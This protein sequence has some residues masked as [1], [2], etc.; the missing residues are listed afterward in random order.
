MILLQRIRA[1]LTS[2]PDSEH[3]M[4]LNR[5][6]FCLVIAAY[7]VAARP[8]GE[9]AGLAV[10]GAESLIGLG[11]FVHILRHPQI[12]WARRAIAMA[13]DIGTIS[14][15][16]YLGGGATSVFFPIYLWVVFGNGF[17]FG[18]PALFTSMGVAVA[19]FIAVVAATPFWRDSMQLS[20]GL[21]L[22]LIILPTY[23]A[24]L[25]RKLSKARL[26][27]EEASQAKSHFLAR[28]SH[29]LRTP[30][31]AIIGMGALL[32]DTDLGD[33]QL[34]MT[35]T[36]RTAAKSLLS[37]IDGLL[38][39]SRIEADLMPI[40]AVDFDL[41]P[42]LAEIRAMVSVQAR[43]K[44]LRLSL[45]VTARTATRLRGDRR[46][47]AEIL[48]NLASNAVKFTDEGSVVI[49]VDAETASGAEMGPA[50]R[51][52]VRF[53]VS[54]T[55]IGIKPEA[56][57]HIFERFTQADETIVNRF[58]GTGLGLAIC[59][60]L[61]ELLGGEIGVE[62]E[63]G[64][65]SIFRVTLDL[66]LQDNARKS[67]EPVP[68][69]AR[70]LLVTLDAA[71][72]RH[73]K[74]HAALWGV[75][76]A[77]FGSAAEAIAF[78][79]DSL[80]APRR[81]I[82][83]LHQA[84]MS[85]D[86]HAVASALHGALHGMPHGLDAE[87]GFPVILIGDAPMAGLPAPHIRS[88][89][90]MVLSPEPS[91]QELLAA[92]A[93]TLPPEGHP[94]PAPIGAKLG[95]A[96]VSR[97]LRILVADDNRINQSVIAKILE[98]AGHQASVVANGEEALDALAD[99]KFDLVLMDVNM[100]V[101]NGIQATKVFRFASLGGPHVPIA[102]LTADIT[103][104]V[105][106]RCREA[107]MDACITKPIEPAR[108]LEIIEQLV[109]GAGAEGLAE[110]RL[111]EIT[112]RPSST[113]IRA[114][115]ID[116]GVLQ[117]L[118]DLG[119]GAFVDDLLQEFLGDADRRLQDFAAAAAAVDLYGFSDLT[120]ALRSGAAN[121]GAKAIFELCMSWRDVNAAELALNGNSFVRQ[122]KVEF[123]R[124]HLAANRCRHRH[125]TLGSS[126][127]AKICAAE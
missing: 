82:L 111:P 69:G 41:L 18:V 30:L 40:H 56:Q 119:G 120:H 106:Q 25:I 37:Q 107:G 89:F 14:L 73:V 8:P 3:E 58:G 67:P 33:E 21:L 52:R 60:K 17:R 20:A 98:R 53:E 49:A 42:L 27:A 103:P 77:S 13:A 61:V 59:K 86:V 125:F 28:V 72:V 46:H 112:A 48:L 39:F 93:L 90:T 19:A 29:E 55:G 57:A 66:D 45:H 65:G 74:G 85:A 96:R 38:D 109:R 12:C 68:A 118:E 76:V 64:A 105:A 101:M 24:S 87:G 54:D 5:L 126:G 114:P 6:A 62:S 63:E 7:L 124:L 16:L 104:E 100:P 32:E 84:G 23:T 122:L 81:S 113:P 26:Q 99:N 108:L 31:N 121:L 4:S 34:E 78:V 88:H 123:E 11:I 36:V 44:G 50:G 15:E 51:Q 2:R 70:I 22:G 1:S 97:V 110:I 94:A 35:R 116:E 79:G 43:A 91:R 83:M 117:N 127:P 95:S 47:I 102:A 115:A 80:A 75:A 92:L 71:M 10:I 9:A